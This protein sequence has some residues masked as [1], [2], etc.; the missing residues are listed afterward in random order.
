VK[1]RVPDRLTHWGAVPLVRLLAATWRVDW[2]YRERWQQGLTSATPRLFLLWHE[3]LLPL[4]WFHRGHGVAIVVSDARD[5][6][7]LQ[8]FAQRLG[9]EPI[10]G[11]SRRGAVKAM[12]RAQRAL[13][14]GALVAVTP[15]G[16]LGPRRVLKPGMLA[17]A[18]RTGATIFT[19]H[20]AARPA[21]RLSSWDRFVIPAPFAQVRVAYGC[22]FHVDPG[23]DGVA[24]AAARAAADL[25]RLEQEIQWPDRSVPT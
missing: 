3:V 13:E 12:R 1:I 19:V 14:Q 8:H 4:L 20:A 2:R 18:Q 6:R 5:G 7:Y 16:P 15:D 11:S 9:Y 10:G 17:A 22:P 23:P 21:L 24:R 25:A